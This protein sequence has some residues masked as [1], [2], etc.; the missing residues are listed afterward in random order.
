MHTVRLH[1]PLNQ[2]QEWIRDGDLLLFRRRGLI[3]AVGRG[4]HSHA[5]LAGWWGETLC[6]LEVRALYGGRV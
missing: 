2:A 6:C 1:V 4:E 3:A 5:A